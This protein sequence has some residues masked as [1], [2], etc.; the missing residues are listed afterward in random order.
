MEREET[1]F[2]KR[3]ENRDK[4]VFMLLV[5]SIPLHTPQFGKNEKLDE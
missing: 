2:N 5:Y 1:K 4:I 3:E